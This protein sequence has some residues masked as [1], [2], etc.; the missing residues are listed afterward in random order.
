MTLQER[1]M[2]LVSQ[3]T[4]NQQQ[5]PNQFLQGG[6]DAIRNNDATKGEEIANKILQQ[7]GISREQAMAIARQRGII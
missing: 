1:A 4:Q 6:L 2:Q 5:A 3:I 7:A